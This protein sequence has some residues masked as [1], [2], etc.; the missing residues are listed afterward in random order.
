[1]RV[2]S[3]IGLAVGPVDTTHWGQV[4][5]TPSAYGI[6]E[7]SDDAGQAQQKGARILSL[8]GEKLSAPLTNL[9][10]VEKAAQDAW[11]AGITSLIVFVC[12]QRV[13]Y[14]VV[15]GK[16]SV[17]VKRG[18]ELAKLM[19]GEGSVS[20]E[21]REGDTILLVS[22]KFAKVLTHADIV[23]MFDLGNAVD[24]AQKLTIA[25]HEHQGAEGAVALVFEVEKFEEV[26]PV[27][28]TPQEPQKK[29][30][31]KRTAYFIQHLRDIR[32]N[33]VRLRRALAILV[34]SV[35]LLSV[36]AGVWKQT[37]AKKNEHATIVLSD[38]Q[39]AFEE[40]VALLEL[41]PVKGRERLESAKS[42]LEPEVSSVNPRTKLGRDIQLLFDQVNDNLTQSLQITQGSLALFYDMELLKKGAAATSVALSGTTLIVGDESGASVYRLDIATKKAAILAGGIQMT[43]VSSVA[44]HGD[45]MYAL[46][47]E[48]ITATNWEDKKT[49]VVVPKNEAWGSV[50]SLISFGGNL[51]LLDSVKSRIWK[52]TATEKGFSDIREYLNPD[53]LPDLSRAT[54]MTIDGTVW[55]GTRQ[56]KIFRFVQGKEE[57]FLPKGVEPALGADVMVYVTDENKN[58]YVLDRLNNRVVVLDKDG[59]YLSQY[60][61]AAGS[62]VRSFVVS[63]GEKKILLLADGKIFSI[64][65]K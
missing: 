43:G 25:L 30:A 49:I 22:E 40:G 47:S 15:C 1:M 39:H 41:N 28:V 34:T 59:V 12:V 4:L 65:L 29:E 6:L 3:S 55:V 60:R 32:H 2:K 16:G 57:T 8:L 52:Y 19:Q 10:A 56:G 37:T 58:M 31:S 5:V 21:V 24:I 36:V 7:V 17:F 26:E 27:I 9:S 50:S 38:A 48:G 42:L 23:G 62:N 46:T 35:F 61:F 53:T 51:Y 20:G 44:Q 64:D 33:P 63:E 14:L 18:R 45:I 13:V 54:N 11:E